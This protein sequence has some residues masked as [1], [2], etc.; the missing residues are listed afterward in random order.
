MEKRIKGFEWEFNLVDDKAVNAWAMPGG[1]IVVYKGILPIT[2]ND[3]GMAVVMGHE[4]AHIVAKHGNERMSQQLVVQMGGMAL[5]VAMKEKPEQTRA[6]F[7]Q[8]YGVTTQVGVML[9]YSRKHEYE[10]DKL[11]LVFMAMAGYNPE[12]A[13]KFWEKMMA[14]G[15]AKPPE[16]LSTHPSDE[17][18]IAELKKYL[19]EA[20]KYYKK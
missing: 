4:I 15:G 5:D 9:P 10:A 3:T 17:N 2:K 7:Q 13:I 11:G 16:F 18:R 8:A 14:Q 20:M 1:K 12:S 6:I 19:P